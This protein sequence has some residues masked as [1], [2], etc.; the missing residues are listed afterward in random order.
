MSGSVTNIATENL[1]N[2]SDK[3]S[4][5]NRKS[6]L[7]RTIAAI[8][9]GVILFVAIT[10]QLD[11]MYA[12]H[13]M[14]DRILMHS[15]ESEKDIDIVTLGS[16]H[17]FCDI[18]PEVLDA[19]SGMKSFN[20]ATPSQRLDCTYYLLKQAL[21]Q[22]DLK[23]VYIECYY[24]CGAE[25]E[26]WDKTAAEY[27]KT[28]VTKDP[29]NYA[30]SWALS[31]AMKPTAES[32]AIRLGAADVEHGMETVFPF[33]RYREKLF[34]GEYIKETIATK[35]SD[36][37]K[38]YIYKYE[39]TDADGT[40]YTKEYCPKGYLSDNGGKLCDSE[41]LYN[42]VRNLSD[43]GMGTESRKWLGKI[44]SLCQKKGVE[45][46]LFTAPMYDLQLIST[47]DYDRYVKELRAVADEYG[48]EY[49]DFNL[50]KNEYL[51]IKHG[52]YFM[53]MG[54]LNSV[55]AEQFTK[56]FWET[57]NE[58]EKERFYD[59]YKDKLAAE[60]SEIFGLYY[61]YTEPDGTMDAKG[62]PVYKSREYHVAANRDDVYDITVTTSDGETI[63]FENVNSF[64]LPADSHGSIEVVGESGNITVNY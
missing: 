18:S 63:S 19:E 1:I 56:A 62:A 21:R 17:V 15:Y 40:V 14:W 7:I 49:Y 4:G 33:V 13:D 51:D 22:H 42:R 60:P 9:A 32:A 45:I 11:Y 38:N 29:A 6:T 26:I 39:E 24:W 31:Y 54:H 27:V 36:D 58:T 64:T 53:N 28:E 41:K 25:Y 5:T 2:D 44:I 10:K 3:V 35:K 43:Y 30:T 48:I 12:T 23:K 50:M 47:G 16:S 34:D 37:Y 46:T 20:L 52:E 61:F 59:S 57:V 55:G 8:L